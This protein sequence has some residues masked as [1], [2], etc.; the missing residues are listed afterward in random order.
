M[1]EGA[2]AYASGVCEGGIQNAE[3]WKRIHGICIGDV[4]AGVKLRP[5]V[6]CIGDGEAGVKLRPNSCQLSFY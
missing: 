6:V 2:I 1:Y 5:N 4:K 3:M